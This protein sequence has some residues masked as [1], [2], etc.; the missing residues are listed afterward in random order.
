MADVAMPVTKGG[1]TPGINT[2]STSDVNGYALHSAEDKM[3]QV[4]SLPVTRLIEEAPAKAGI[5]AR[6]IHNAVS[7]LPGVS[8]PL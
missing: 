1:A 5:L 8:S 6:V 3:T 2:F 7:T 4:L